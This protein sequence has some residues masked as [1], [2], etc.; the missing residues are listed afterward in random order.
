MSHDTP[1]P[2]G[3]DDAV[4]PD[5][6]PAEPVAQAAAE[7]A[8]EPVAAEPVAAAPAE[9]TAPTDAPAFA[10]PAG[11]PSIG[12]YFAPQDDEADAYYVPAGTG[13]VA[14]PSLIARLGAE[15][16]GAFFLV[17]AGVGVALYA[18][19]GSLGGGTLAVGL[20]FGLAVLAGIAAVGHV[21]G[22]HFNPAVTLGA[23]LGG[24]TPWRDVLPY[25]LAQVIGGAV[26]AAVL[27]VAIPKTLPP[28][29]SQKEGDTA[30][31]F[32]DGVSN[33]FGPHSPLHTASS[34]ATSFPLVTA[35]LVEV[36]VTAIFVGVILGVTDRR[37]S[38]GQAPVAIGLALA[39]LILVAIPV[40]NASLNPARSTA[41]AI[42]ANTWALKQL[43]LFW[44]APL[45]GGAIAGLVYR[46]FAAEPVEDNLLEEDDLYVTDEDVV[47][48]DER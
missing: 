32:F 14:T 25:W 40:T 41:T 43:W 13:V 11:E 18:S 45:V 17:L 1:Q 6:T 42:F 31:D 9:P 2:T 39:I 8:A 30:R 36:V 23:A 29:I 4:E 7:P 22:G 26:G 24:R 38:K 48:V 35:L 12:D 15:A 46:A 21:S 34:G 10:P 3:P 44:V 19:V 37:A 28:L 27:F 20:A 16:F 33:G 5:T 47:V